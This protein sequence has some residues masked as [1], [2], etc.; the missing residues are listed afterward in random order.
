V[1]SHKK[2]KKLDE[3]VVFSDRDYNRFKLALK[4]NKLTIRAYS[5]RMGY[6]HN[7]F[8]VFISKSN[9]G[10][11]AKKYYLPIIEYTNK[12]YDLINNGTNPRGMDIVGH[13]TPVDSWA[14]VENM[15]QEEIEQIIADNIPELYKYIKSNNA[16]YMAV[17][18]IRKGMIKQI[19]DYF[20]KLEDS[21]VKKIAHLENITDDNRRSI[22]IL[23][24]NARDKDKLMDEYKSCLEEVVGK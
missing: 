9:R 11:F 4:M 14:Y 24:A 8:R 3:Y 23:V 20:A 13:K 15:K 12:V 1:G 22:V 18:S 6:N 19:R 7:S 21:V 5:K 16:I 17:Q 2:R 10:R